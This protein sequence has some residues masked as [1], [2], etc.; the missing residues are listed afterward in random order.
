[1]N[2]AYHPLVSD[3]ILRLPGVTAKNYR[4]LMDEAVSLKNLA[5]L[6]VGRLAQ[7]LGNEAFATQLKSFLEAT[8]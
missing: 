8:I 6:S 3:L 7:I 1:M 5:G 2:V 4:R